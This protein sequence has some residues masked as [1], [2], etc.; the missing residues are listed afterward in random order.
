MEDKEFWKKR[1]GASWPN[2]VRRV[3]K[4]INAFKSKG[5][6]AVPHGFLPLSTEY[7]K[8][9]PEEKGD[10]D[11]KILTCKETK[12]IYV[13]VT[14]PDIAISKTDDLWIRWDKFIY[15]EN[16][17]EKEI[18]VVHILESE[19]DLMRV[20]KLGSGIK[21]RYELIHPTI[22]GTVESYRSIPVDDPNVFSFGNFCKYLQKKTSECSQ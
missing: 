21:E 15:A 7:V 17:P 19:D 8:E 10:P 13:E 11:L 20:L 16:H 6:K 14:G 1:Y 18:W 3:E 22:R 12:E 2:A 5:I 9:S 4:V